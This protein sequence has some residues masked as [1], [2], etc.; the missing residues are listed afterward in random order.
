MLQ[1]K[2][3]YADEFGNLCEQVNAFLAT[4]PTHKVKDV[5]FHGSRRGE[6]Q[7]FG[8]VIVYEVQP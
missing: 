2:W 3:F 4:L 5:Q 6:N 7:V 1:V 8:A